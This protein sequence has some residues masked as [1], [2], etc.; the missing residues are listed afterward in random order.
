[1][2]R[3]ALQAPQFLEHRADLSM[4]LLSFGLG[5]TG[6]AIGHSQNLWKFTPD[7]WMPAASR[8]GGGDAPAR[9]FSNAFG[10]PSFTLMKQVS[11]QQRYGPKS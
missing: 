4:G 9:F 8:G 1:M 7:R 6:A 11:F 10:G 5:A 3:A 2:R